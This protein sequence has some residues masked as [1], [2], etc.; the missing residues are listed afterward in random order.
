M[1]G[2]ADLNGRPYTPVKPRPWL[3]EAH[4]A[5]VARDYACDP[6]EVEYR[7]DQKERSEA[8]IRNRM[9]YERGIEE[10]DLSLSLFAREHAEGRVGDV[11]VKAVAA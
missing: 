1:T 11:P 5:K 4:R 8:Y 9:G 3:T 6:R 7:L 10:I 2:P